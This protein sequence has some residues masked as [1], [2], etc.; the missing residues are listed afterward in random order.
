MDFLGH[1][2]VLSSCGLTELFPGPSRG[3]LQIPCWREGSWLFAAWL[4]HVHDGDRDTLGVGVG[5]RRRFARSRR[6]RAAW[7]CPHWMLHRQSFRYI[8]SDAHRHHRHPQT[9]SGG[10]AIWITMPIQLWRRP[11]GVDGAGPDDGHK[12]WSVVVLATCHYW[13]ACPCPALATW[14]D[15]L[16][17]QHKGTERSSRYSTRAHGCCACR[18]CL[19]PKKIFRFPVTSNL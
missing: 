14:D 1:W 4:H 16:T 3:L 5:W 18:P 2:Q 13:C 9:T 15:D 6:P 17:P 7:I 8:T 10:G 12:D 19:V 11:I